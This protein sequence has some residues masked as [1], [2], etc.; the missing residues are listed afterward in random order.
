MKI[1][2][3]DLDGTLIKTGQKIHGQAFKFA[4]K[5]VFGIDADYTHLNTFG[6]IDGQILTEILAFYNIPK[7]KSQEKLTEMFLEMENYFIEH[8]K[9]TKF[10]TLPGAYELVEELYMK[11]FP[12]A[13]LTGNIEIFGWKKLEKTGLK[14]FIT[15]G[16][17]GNM[18]LRRSD[19][20][21]IALEKLQLKYDKQIQ[22]SNL[23]IIGDTPLD[24]RCAKEGN[25]YSIGVATSKY[26]KG[27]LE[28]EGA[29]FVVDS[30]LQKKDIIDFLMK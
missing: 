18:A 30:L 15:T 10:E 22:K 19:L 28:A 9:E 4:I 3:F 24:I 21:P 8:E 1:P 25:I 5:K 29:D 20:I 7:K 2:L 14:R 23:V 12:L 27:D 13:V 6:M 26:S 17:F 11:N 16:A